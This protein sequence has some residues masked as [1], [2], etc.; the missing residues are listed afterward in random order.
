MKRAFVFLCAFLIATAL[1]PGIVHGKKIDLRRVPVEK[2]DPSG[3]LGPGNPRGIQ[4]GDKPDEGGIYIAKE[5]DDRWHVVGAGMI[6]WGGTDVEMVA[7]AINAGRTEGKIKPKGEYTAD[8]PGN[9]FDSPEGGQIDWAKIEGNKIEWLTWYNGTGAWDGVWF[10]VEGDFLVFETLGLNNKKTGA[11]NSACGK[12][13]DRKC[14]VVDPL[15]PAP[16]ERIFIGGDNPKNWEHPKNEAP[17]ALK[18]NPKAP[19]TLAVELKDKAPTTWGAVKD[20]HELK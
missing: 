14:L 18:N 9:V 2:I 20:S 1:A 6:P 8:K 7:L 13:G 17:F 16:V 10:E 3:M 19:D 4:L 11:A 12:F 15:P 5:P